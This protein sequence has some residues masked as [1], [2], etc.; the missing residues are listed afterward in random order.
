MFSAIV[1]TIA[2]SDKAAL[3][4]LLK[5]SVIGGRWV[6]IGALIPALLFLVSGGILAGFQGEAIQWSA[7]GASAEY[8]DWP[9]SVY[10]VANSVCYGYGEEM[11]WRG[12]ALPRLQ[13]TMSALRASFVVTVAWAAWHLPLFAFSPGLSNLGL[14]GTVG[15]LISLALGSILLTWL[16]NSSGGS[17]A[18]VAFFHACLDVFMTASASPQLVNVMG[19]LLTV[20]ALTLIPLFGGQHLANRTRVIE[21]VD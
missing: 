20:G 17:V 7:V 21:P 5:R 10:W 1:T 6:V 9:R 11:G 12:F 14:G 8:P 4:R 18:A 2:W 3:K 13:A 15:W 19:A 16:F